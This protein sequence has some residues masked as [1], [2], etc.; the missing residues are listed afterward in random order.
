MNLLGTSPFLGGIVAR[1]GQ[2]G[3][4]NPVSVLSNRIEWP[5]LRL[6]YDRGTKTILL[7]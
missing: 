1:A 5:M 4:V 6:T 2:Q 3:P 7:A